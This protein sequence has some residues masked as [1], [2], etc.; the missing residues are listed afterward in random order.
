MSFSVSPDVPLQPEL[1]LPS[2]LRQAVR[3]QYHKP[4]GQ[5]VSASEQQ[6][7]AFCSVA[8]FLGLRR[9]FSIPL[10]GYY[11]GTT[12]IWDSDTLR[13]Q[14]VCRQSYLDNLDI[15]PEGIWLTNKLLI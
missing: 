10:S 9:L 5:S 2:A 1:P 15:M 4:Q 8:T 7:A 3:M 12:R 13:K 11:A 6:P 14:I